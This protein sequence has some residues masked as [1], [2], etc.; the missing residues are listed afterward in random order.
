MVVIVNLNQ[1][2]VLPLLFSQQRWVTPSL[3]DDVSGE[4]SESAVIT[5]HEL[6]TVFTSSGR[7][8]GYCFTKL[9]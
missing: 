1:P 9:I 8:K 5:T 7:D 4:A 3:L 6:S 2:E